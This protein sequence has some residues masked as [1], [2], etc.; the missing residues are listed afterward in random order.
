MDKIFEKLK[1]FCKKNIRSILLH[2]LFLCLYFPLNI[3]MLKISSIEYNNNTWN[4]D[5]LLYVIS[6][7]SKIN[8]PTIQTPA[9][10]REIY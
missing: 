8:L 2:L 5:L 10:I 9:D 3:L 1:I 7:V 4:F 6:L